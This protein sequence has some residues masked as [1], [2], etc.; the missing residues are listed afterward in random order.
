M[1]GPP[2]YHP[3]IHGA[4]SDGQAGAEFHDVDSRS[5]PASHLRAVFPIGRPLRPDR[6]IEALGLVS[7]DLH[8]VQKAPATVDGRVWDRGTPVPAPGSPW[9][10]VPTPANPDPSRVQA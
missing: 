4:M 6:R 9:T 1:S 3:T 5:P 8:Q 10:R 2:V 7:L